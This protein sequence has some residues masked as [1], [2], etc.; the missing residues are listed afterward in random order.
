MRRVL[1]WWRRR[2]NRWDDICVDENARL[3]TNSILCLMLVTCL[4]FFML[5][6]NLIR[7]SLPLI[8]LMVVLL[9]MYGSTFVY[10][11][12]NPRYQS[13]A[14]WIFGGM[15]MVMS[16]VLVY[17]GT[18]GGLGFLWVFIVPHVAVMVVPFKDSLLYNG[19]LLGVMLVMLDTPLHE[20][21]MYSY[22]PAF[23]ILFPV[24]LLAVMGCIYIAE[25]VRA[26]TQ[27]RLRATAE[28]LSSFAFTDPLTGAYN[29]HALASHFGEVKA[30]PADG[31]AFAMLD[32]DFFKQVN[33]RYGHFTGD[34]MLQHVVRLTSGSVPPNALLYRW[35]G[36]EFLL[37]LK[38]SDTEEVRCTL[39]K[40]RKAVEQTPLVA[41][42]NEIAI[43]LS[44]GAVCAPPGATI[45]QCI[46]RADEQL[47]QAKE[48]GRNKVVLAD[49]PPPGTD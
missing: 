47:Y 7:G 44:L 3:R 35:G 38:T 16:V 12:L 2:L 42:E 30:A 13:W 6:V 10:Q 14:A 40:V 15:A 4:C 22:A 17:L 32:L 46:A 18:S 49:C 29:R 19:L 20:K 11:L 9:V 21:L 39:E 25:M 24:A 34:K 31:L 5:V 48:T 36:E 27:S 1:M 43:T 23:R 33:D 45:R 8:I 37:V 41:G 26:R 28:K